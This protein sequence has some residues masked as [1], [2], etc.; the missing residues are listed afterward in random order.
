M[1]ASIPG[2][3]LCQTRPRRSARAGVACRAE[4][5]DV[6]VIGSGIGGL[7]AGRVSGS[8]GE[9]EARLVSECQ[10]E[11]TPNSQDEMP[12]RSNITKFTFQVIY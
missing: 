9:G 4:E 1:T 5:V 7:C 12:L 11:K 6:V 8:Q 2:T 10:D 3:S